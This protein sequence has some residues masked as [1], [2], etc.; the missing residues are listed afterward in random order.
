MRIGSVR[1]GAAV[2]MLVGLWLVAGCG[3]GKGSLSGTVTVKGK[4]LPAGTVTAK[5]ADGT[6]A[7][8][9]VS[10]GR[11]QVDGVSRGTVK[12]SVVAVLEGSGPVTDQKI[13]RDPAYLKA[14]M[15][16]DAKEIAKKAEENKMVIGDNYQDVEKSPLTHDTSKGW[17]F[18]IE[19]P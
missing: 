5:C 18:N 15:E 2:L 10:N 6:V 4:P 19:I 13:L 9:S 7:A 17:T 14:K 1:A 8:G 16:R 12:I 11:Y 3:G